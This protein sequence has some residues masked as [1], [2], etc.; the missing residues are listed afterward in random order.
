MSWCW[1]GRR[2]S[3]RSRRLAASRSSSAGP[4]WRWPRSEVILPLG[5]RA[6]RGRVRAGD[7][8]EAREFG[9]RRGNRMTAKRSLAVAALVV[10]AASGACSRRAAERPA[11]GAIPEAPTNDRMTLRFFRN[12]AVAPEFAA[13]DLDGKQISL[14]DFRGKV[15]LVNFWAT[16]CGP[17]KAEI[18]DLIA[19]QAKYRD[20]LQVIGI[21][22][23]EIAPELVR[24]FTV[25][26][27]MNYPV[28]MMTPEIQKLFPGVSAIPTSFL[29]SRESR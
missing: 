21:S 16:W 15:I 8:D 14:A 4:V 24:R 3:A 26:Y 10:L 11:S 19:L 5:I 9:T 23:D 17:C 29:I 7:T 1:G 13:R 25:E 28:V 6:G 22:E 2:R 12:P 27:K 20:Y 18:P